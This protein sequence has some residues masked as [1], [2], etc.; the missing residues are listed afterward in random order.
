MFNG[1]R[2]LVLFSHDSLYLTQSFALKC[3]KYFKYTLT[4]PYLGAGIGQQFSGKGNREKA[5]TELTWQ[6]KGTDDDS[7]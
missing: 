5:K 4:Q 6:I 2:Q 7:R 3:C 1:F